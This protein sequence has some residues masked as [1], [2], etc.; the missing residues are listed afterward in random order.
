MRWLSLLHNQR[1]IFKLIILNE[2]SAPAFRKHANFWKSAVKLNTPLSSVWGFIFPAW[3][4]TFTLVCLHWAEAVGLINMNQPSAQT[5]LSE[6][7]TAALKWHKLH[8]IVFTVHTTAKHTCHRC[9]C[10]LYR[11]GHVTLLELRYQF[12]ERSLSSGCGADGL[13]CPDKSAFLFKCKKYEVRF[14]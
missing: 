2:A 12:D 9:C 3:W 1:G 8:F 4:I 14:K 6:G 5:R 13:S 7:K 10:L 11:C